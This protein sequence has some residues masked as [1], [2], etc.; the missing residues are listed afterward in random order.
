[1]AKKKTDTIMKTHQ[2]IY[3]EQHSIVL[4]METIS[5]AALLIDPYQ[6]GYPIIFV[7]R[8]FTEMTGYTKQEIRERNYTL[9][10]DKATNKKV[11]QI[12]VNAMKYEQNAM[13]ETLN[14]RKDGTSFWIEIN[15]SPLYNEHGEVYA[16]IGIQKDISHKKQTLTNETTFYGEHGHYEHYVTFI[17]IHGYYEKM[18]QN[19]L[20]LKKIEDANMIGKSMMDFIVDDDKEKVMNVF[21]SA[22]KGQIEHIN[23]RGFHYNGDIVELNVLYIPSYDQG[24]INGVYTI[25]KNITGSSDTYKLT[26]NAHKYDVAK[27][28]A[29]TI[30]DTL[31]TPLTTLKGLIHLLEVNLPFAPD[32]TKLMLTEIERMEMATTG[33]KH[34][35]K[36]RIIQTYPKNVHT[37]LENICRVM[38]SSTLKANI[39]LHLDYKTKKE[40]INVDQKGIEYIF[41]QLIKNAVE[42]MPSGGDVVIEVK[43][44]TDGMLLIQFIDEGLGIEKQHLKKVKE[45]FYTTKENRVGIALTLC[46]SII[47]EH[48]GS[49]TFLN[50]K[51]KGT[52]AEVRLPTF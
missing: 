43:H 2:K 1:M 8:G 49:L 27:R 51:S 4:M 38:Y 52:I 24:K 23:I 29:L 14:Y 5:E 3:N 46:E 7:N 19:I 16:F 22:L 47:N 33:I 39:Q 13:V 48:K 37:I 45:P 17:N 50:R 18:N 26:I 10:E 31:D 15:L 34:I 35:L 9:L 20:G 30:V 44:Q 28:I 11:S 25:F 41:I 12:M 21:N 32:Y 42:S 36:P 6:E 40:A